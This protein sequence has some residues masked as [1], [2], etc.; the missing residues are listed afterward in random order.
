[1]NGIHMQ[2]EK[3]SHVQN[4]KSLNTKTFI[5]TK[6]LLINPTFVNK[7]IGFN[8]CQ[9]TWYMNQLI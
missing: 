6:Q 7:S 5:Q 8:Q 2:K 4:A 3:L 9:L 1:M